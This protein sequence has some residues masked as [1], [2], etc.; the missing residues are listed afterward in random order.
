MRR[1]FLGLTAL[2][3]LLAAPLPVAAQSSVAP[4]FLVIVDTSGSMAGSTGSGNNS[5]GVPRRRMN[6]AKCVLQRVVNGYGDVV[7]GL[8]R[9]TQ[10]CSATSCTTCNNSVCGCG[11]A[12]VGSCTATAASG[13]VIV[14]IRPDN[15]ADIVEWTNGSCATCGSSA[16]GSNPELVAEGNTPLGGA[17]LAA[18]QYYTGATSP[19][20]GDP[21]G[22]CRPV[23]VI[24]L[25]DGDETCSGNAVTAATQLRSTTVGGLTYDIK[26][27]VIGFG[28]TAGDADI[29]GMAT[30]GGTDAPGANRGFY[31]TDETSLALAFSQIVSDSLRFEV[32]N[33]SDD[34]CDARIDEGF[35][36]YCN[37]P[38]GTTT[39][40]L[41]ADPGETRCD[42]AD[43]N[44]NGR[45]DEGLLNAC[46]TCGAA[47]AEACNRVDDDCDGAI[48]ESNVCGA[49]SPT[50]EIC[51]NR[52]N[53]CDGRTDE[54]LTRA[55][56]SNVGQCLPGTQT[57]SAGTWGTCSGTG[58]TAELCDNLDN[59][60]NGV[61]DGQIEACGSSVG[62]CVPGRRQCL[63]GVYGSCIGAVGPIAEVCN[64]VDDDC[65]GR[66][67]EGDPGGG[68]SCGNTAGT[69][70]AGTLHCVAGGLVCQGGVGPSTESCNNQDDDCDGRIDEGNP[71][72]GA[73]CGTTDQ[74]ECAYGMQR[75]VSGGL[76]CYGAVGPQAERCNNLDDDCDGLVDE[77]N[78]EGG[79]RCG[80]DT[81]ECAAGTNQCRLG[82]LTC[83]GAVGPV[84]ELCNGRDDDCDGAIDDEI[85]VGS[86]CGTDV[87]ECIPGVNVCDP[88]TGG[89]VCQGEV[90][91]TIETCN[92]LDDDCD[93]NVD[94]EIAATGTCGV[95]VGL[96]MEGALQ[97][98]NGQEICVGEVPPGREVCDC[99]D[100]D[101]DGAVDET[102]TG[103]LCPDGSACVQCQC[104][105][106]C[107]ISEYG[108][109]CPTGRVPL[110]EGTAC[111]CVEDVCD[112]AA[113][114]EQT[115]E[116]DGATVCA[117]GST[118]VGTCQCVN[119]QCSFACDGVVC[120]NGLAC[121]PRDPRGRCV[122]DNCRGLGCPADQICDR[123]TGACVADPCTAAGCTAEQ[124]CR[125][126]VCE[127]SCANV[128][129]PA[130]QTCRSGSCAV[131]RC[132]GISCS[133]T[134]VCNPATGG[135]VANL[136]T[137]PCLAGAV[138]DPITGMCGAGPCDRVRCPTDEF[139]YQ[140]ECRSS[141]V[142]DGG[143]SDQDGGATFDGGPRELRV[144]AAGGGCLCA[145]PG[146][147]SARGNASWIL[148]LMLAMA[149]GVRRARRGMGR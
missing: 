8:E 73:Q 4:Y 80:D 149:V 138:C 129:C 77:G 33:G 71:G 98:V 32:C 27:Y 120:P 105:V 47:P 119:N 87:G 62:R 100:N 112:D 95:T 44:C 128:E 82:T 39:Q 96:C 16:P 130:G 125:N 36:R 26:T 88:S 144:Q 127:T 17:L 18:R 101:C 12:C 104:A 55:C 86:P 143:V 21:Y 2:F 31:A 59:D 24:L 91:P 43:D 110:M 83:V 147:R 118:D 68:G 116:R 48:D 76:T 133:G 34:D 140:G 42:G 56:G 92:L 108:V 142:P 60:C 52:D 146:S 131:D 75:C 38:A 124:A 89:L 79:T 74:G 121:D 65:D 13:Q 6:D 90:G 106:A 66:T 37:R 135:C 94:E 97:C 53:D 63:A 85:P 126:G 111:F 14:P 109:Q 7:F 25:T 132:A 78:P 93:G 23:S 81:G 139:C 20:I 123:P 40:T 58:P 72:G 50:T 136:C 70:S 19:L 54:S 9:F 69:C 117:P 29:E 41:C 145:T 102:T 137:V 5:C 28:V 46:G 67:D 134:N 148:G 15:Q 99:D 114:A 115:I 10:T 49:C 57:C 113:C 11:S 61:I 122:E 3:A 64:A 1:C 141:V 51:D 30:A 103:S 107:V 84:A 22:T 35:T 45:V